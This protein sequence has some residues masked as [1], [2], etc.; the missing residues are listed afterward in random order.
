[1]LAPEKPDQHGWYTG[2][3]S[4]NFVYKVKGITATEHTEP[5]TIN[6]PITTTE[7]IVPA[8]APTIVGSGVGIRVTGS[9]RHRRNTRRRVVRRRVVRRRVARRRVARRR[10]A[11]RLSLIHIS[12]PRDRG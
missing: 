8:A 9:R 2:A 10:V 7:Q 6:A 12:S 4:V 5:E 3:L 1:M 11:R